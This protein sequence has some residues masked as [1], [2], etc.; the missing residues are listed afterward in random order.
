MEISESSC[1]D[2]YLGQSKRKLQVP[3]EG[4]SRSSSVTFP[5]G[6]SNHRAERDL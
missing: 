4:I 2:K 3:T 5:K 1:A 6:C